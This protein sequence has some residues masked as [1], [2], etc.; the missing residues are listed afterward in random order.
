MWG[1]SDRKVQELVL[2]A[3]LLLLVG[4]I[5]FYV[6]MYKAWASIQD[7][8]TKT[9]PGKAVGFSFIP[10]FNIYWMF[11]AIGSWGREYN[12][13]VQRTGKQSNFHASEGLF[14]THCVLQLLV[15]GIAFLITMPMVISQMCNGI[16]ALAAGNLPR[17]ELRQ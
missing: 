5:A 3:P 12:S 11:V 9:T 16:N 10:F 17:A 7:G 8:Y 2:V 15:G 4:F 6:L 1:M 13:Y 14:T